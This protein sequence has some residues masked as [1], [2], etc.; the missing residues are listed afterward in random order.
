MLGLSDTNIFD[1]NY[2]TDQQEIIIR[3][4]LQEFREKN[5]KL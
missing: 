3:S 4:L 2:L 1:T 5:S